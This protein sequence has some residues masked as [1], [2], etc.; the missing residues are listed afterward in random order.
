MYDVIFYNIILLYVLTKLGPVLNV[1]F[2]N[3]LV[4]KSKNA[5]GN[6][7]CS[8]KI[9][10]TRNLYVDIAQIKTMQHILMYI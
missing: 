3:A 5:S 7:W 9:L 1:E 8:Q 2:K 10:E 4:Q 6:K